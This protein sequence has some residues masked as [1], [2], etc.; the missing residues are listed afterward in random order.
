MK[1]EDPETMKHRAAR[2]DLPLD[3]AGGRDAMLFKR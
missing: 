2:V 1:E 3:F